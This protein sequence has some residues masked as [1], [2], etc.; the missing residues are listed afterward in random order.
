MRRFAIIPFVILAAAAPAGAEEPPVAPEHAAALM[1]LPDGFRATLFIGEP[2][3]IKPI[4]MTIDDRGR[5]SGVAFHGS[6]GQACL[7]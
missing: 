3:L 6:S 2:D 5:L 1:T 7:G 4:A